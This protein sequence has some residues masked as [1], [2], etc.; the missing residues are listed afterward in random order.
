MK[1]RKKIC[2]LGV[3]NMGEA[4]LKGILSSGIYK[5]GDIIVS[6]ISEERL[7]HINSTYGVETTKDNAE[8]TT[9]SEF[10]ILAVKPETAKNLI[11]E[12][13]HLIHESKV[14]I[15]LIT[16]LKITSIHKWLKREIPVIRVMPNT[17]VLVKEGATVIAPGPGVKEKDIEVAQ[18][19]FDSVG[20]TVIMG[21]E[22]LDAV[23]G[24]SGSGPAYI[25]TIIEALADG[26]VKVGLPRRESILLAAQTVLGAAKM[27]LETGKHPGSLKDMVTSPGGTTIE[28][29]HRLEASGIRAALISAVEHATRRAKELGEKE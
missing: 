2:I 13:S 9:S 11:G 18:K 20:K 28:G 19:I 4:L 3:G 14:I 25:F 7:T 26:G 24:L 27:V 17:P 22:Y 1:S 21:E 23:T 15:S 8:A 10:I 29:L 12:I 6:D 5:K 16:G